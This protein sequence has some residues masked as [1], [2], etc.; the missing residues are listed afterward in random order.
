MGA[1]VH[2]GEQSEV[3]PMIQS[4]SGLEYSLTRAIKKLSVVDKPAI[5]FIRGQGEPALGSMQGTGSHFQERYGPFAISTIQAA[6]IT[7][8]I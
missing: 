3:L 7:N 8:G 5:G 2:M 1:V 4:T 6:S